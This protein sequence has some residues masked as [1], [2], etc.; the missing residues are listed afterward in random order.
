[1]TIEKT[2]HL[3]G[4]GR[5][6]ATEA[7]NIKI[8]TVLIWNYGEKSKVIDITPRGKKQLLIKEEYTSG[9]CE[10]IVSRSRLV[11]FATL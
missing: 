8:G 7:E 3:I 10:R 9:I 2:K 1:M 4:Y 5:A 6:K 11:A